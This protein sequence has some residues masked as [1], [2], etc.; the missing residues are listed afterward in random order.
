MSQWR[1]R[2]IEVFP[3]IRARIHEAGSLGQLWCDL[4]HRFRQSYEGQPSSSVRIRSIYLYAVWCTKSPSF[5]VQQAA[6]MHFYE[7]VVWFA[8]Q[9]KE[10]LYR[11]VVQ[12]LVLNLGL[13]EIEALRGTLGYLIDS[14]QIDKLMADAEEIDYQLRRR[15]LKRKH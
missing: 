8:F 13:S 10:P 9:C 14:E 15:S 6:W 3:D 1:K 2:A 5:E 12:D 4:W 7:D 11:R